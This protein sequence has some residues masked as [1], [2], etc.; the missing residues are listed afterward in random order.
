MGQPLRVGVVGTGAIFPAYAA[1][2]R[3]LAAVDLVAVADL[4]PARAAAAAAGSGVPARGVDA[5]LADDGVDLVLNLTTPQAHRDV[6]LRAIASGKGVY[7][8]KPLATDP[9]GARAVLAAAAA[10]GVRVGCAPDT[11]LGTGLQTARR[12]IDSGA[13]GRP[14]AATAVLAVPGHELWHPD[15]DFHYRPTGGPLIDMGPYYLTAL[16]TLLGPVV[17]VIGDAHR[18]RDERVI[19]SGPRA[20]ERIPVEVDT[21]VTGVARH[22]SGVLSTLV[23]SFDAV[24]TRACPIEVHGTEASLAVP[25][26]NRFDGDVLV[27]RPGAD[28]WERLPVSAGYRGASRGVGVA[29]LA[30]TPAGAEPRTGGAL[31]LHVLDVM[32][33]LL[34]SARSRAAVEVPSRVERPAAVPLGGPPGGARS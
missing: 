18:G 27:H 29:D 17:S 16:V 13:V 12:A 33:S 14:V 11:V 4:D 2:L 8:E 24:A 6:A 1:T 15:P 7:G 30:L 34:E 32:A 20:G 10:A 31:A 28:G 23:M 3:R 9:D 19:G 22:A 25:D 26:P 21:H 5:L